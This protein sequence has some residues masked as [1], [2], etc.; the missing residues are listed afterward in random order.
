MNRIEPTISTFDID[1]VKDENTSLSSQLGKNNKSNQHPNLQK[2]LATVGT[3]Y[4]GQIIDTI[5]TAMVFIACLHLSKEFEVSEAISSYFILIPPSLYFLFSDGLPKGQSLGK[6]LLNISVVSKSTGKYC[7]FIQ[8][9]MRNV[10]TPFLGTIDAIFIL[11]KKKRR[12]GDYM[13]N[14]IVVKNR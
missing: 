1:D 9:F 7:S 2:Q 14:T 5:I 8:S 12:L 10:L 11:T 13:A 6:K 3:R 4:L